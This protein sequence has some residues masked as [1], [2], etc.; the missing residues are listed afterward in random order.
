M[1]RDTGLKNTKLDVMSKLQLASGHPRQRIR[2]GS[3]IQLGAGR[4]GQFV[5]MRPG[6]DD[7]V[8]LPRRR[9]LQRLP[10]NW[11]PDLRDKYLVDVTGLNRVAGLPLRAGEMEAAIWKEINR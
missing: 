1:Q 11:L 6:A 2:S 9:N 10:P 5:G 8:P 4:P 7:V 3:A